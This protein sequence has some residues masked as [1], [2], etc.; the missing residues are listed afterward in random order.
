MTPGEPDAFAGADKLV[1]AARAE[2]LKPSSVR[3]WL[4]TQPAYTL[5]KPIRKN[6]KRNRVI[7]N[8]KDEQWQAD[9]V[10]VQ[11]LKESNDD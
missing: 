3:S 2:G 9:L 6:F 4:K 7:V 11:S 8:G 5:H 10:D 1:R